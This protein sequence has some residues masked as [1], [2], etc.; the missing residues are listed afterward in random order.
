MLLLRYRNTKAHNES[1]TVQEHSYLWQGVEL[2]HPNH[3]T[4][5][6]LHQSAIKTALLYLF[7]DEI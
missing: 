1:E 4:I 7:A 5:F 6:T 2:S 3:K